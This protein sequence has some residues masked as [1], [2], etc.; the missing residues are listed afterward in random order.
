MIARIAIVTKEE[1]AS[2][3]TKLKRVREILMRAKGF[4]DVQFVVVKKD[5]GKPKTVTDEDGVTR[6]DKAW[7]E[8]NITPV[9]YANNCLWV[10]FVFSIKD[11]NTWGVESG[12]RGNHI[13]DLDDIGEVWVKADENTVE[14]YPDG[15]KWN[16]FEKTLPHEIG[17]DLKRRG[18]TPL[19]IHDFDYKRIRH[20]IESFY[21]KVDA[22][23]Y[24]AL[25][26]R[27]QTLERLF[28]QY[29][30]IKSLGKPIFPL[31]PK[32]RANVTQHFGNKDPRY[33]SGIHNGT[34][35]WLPIGTPIYA[36]MDGEVTEIHIENPSMG[37]AVY[38][39]YGNRSLRLLHLSRLVGRGKY[40]KGE[41]IGYS[42][43]SGDS[44]GAHLHLEVWHGKINPAF[45]NSEALVRANLIDPMVEF[46][47]AV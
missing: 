14:K 34:D 27:L 3:P 12:L 15:V 46:A 32:Y 26:N 40:S 23:D 35:I 18:I 4:D 38:F 47:K 45:L 22:R 33:V 1:W 25:Y 13:T 39:T 30:I 19:E 37:N 9:A 41:I 31:N 8:K 7:F 2:M 42:G 16:R 6:I 28:V 44:T 11:G 29:R 43:N 21:D 36:P 20:D 10:C 17:H 24:S 5:P